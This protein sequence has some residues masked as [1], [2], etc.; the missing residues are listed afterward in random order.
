MFRVIA[1]VFRKGSFH[2]LAWQPL[3]EGEAEKPWIG[4]RAVQHCNLSEGR[5]KAD[6]IREPNHTGTKLYPPT[7]SGV[8][9]W[10]PWLQQH[11]SFPK[12]RLSHPRS[13]AE[14][15]ARE[16]DMLEEGQ[17]G[18]SPAIRLLLGG[19]ELFSSRFRL[20]KFIG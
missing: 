20:C 7:S 11:D 18:A 3:E 15:L 13:Q 6:M 8:D 9:A 10:T 5:L 17:Q 4:F 2:G 16:L 1:E 19:L 14:A 12:S